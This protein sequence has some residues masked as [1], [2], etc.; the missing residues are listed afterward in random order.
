MCVC[1]GGMRA[2]FGANLYLTRQPMN[3]SMHSEAPLWMM[4]MMNNYEEM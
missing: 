2:I 4:M 1:V 3:E